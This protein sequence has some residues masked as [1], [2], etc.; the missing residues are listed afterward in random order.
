MHLPELHLNLPVGQVITEK[1]PTLLY[2]L[3]VVK[4]CGQYLVCRY[5]DRVINIRYVHS[6]QKGI[7]KTDVK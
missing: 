5:S 4:F 3:F 6:V 1:N 2:V 7:G